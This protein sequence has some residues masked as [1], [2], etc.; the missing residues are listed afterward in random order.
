MEHTGIE[1]NMWNDP[2]L[3]SRGQ[4]TS[5]AS[6]SYRGRMANAKKEEMSAF[7]YEAFLFQADSLSEAIEQGQWLLTWQGE[8][9]SSECALW[10][11]RY[12]V[13]NLLDDKRLYAGPRE[14]CDE[15]LVDLAELDDERFED[16][17]SDEELLFDM[18]EDERKEYLDQKRERREESSYK[19][20]Y[21]D[22][23]AEKE[24]QVPEP[25]FRIHFDVPEGMPVPENEKTLALI[26]RTAKFVNNSSE[27]TMEI[28]L[29]AK[30]ATNPNFAFMSKRHHLFQFYKHVRWLMQTGLYEYAEDIRQR[31]LE[32]A[33]MEQE[34]IDRKA[35]AAAEEERK[36]LQVDL[37]KVVEMTTK[38]LKAHQD[39]PI[40]EKKLLSLADK[41]FDFM[42]PGHIWHDYYMTQKH[43][44]IDI[45]EPPHHTTQVDKNEEIRRDDI[46][47]T[48]AT[49][50]ESTTVTTTPKHT[51]PILEDESP[52][53]SDSSRADKISRV[54]RPQKIKELFRQEQREDSED[55]DMEYQ[56]KHDATLDTIVTGTATVDDADTTCRSESTRLRSK[57]RSQ[58]PP[59]PSSQLPVRKR[60]RL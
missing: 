19:G 33:R 24:E 59:S 46:A 6:L 30:Q 10:L 45:Q 32:E 2:D 42:R 56:Q 7:G 25:T 21:Y 60:T 22:Y 38:F 34:E 39:D 20:I 48:E 16:L 57:S 50:K 12:D 11:D 13:R 37:V 52:K 44:N 15:H 8:D 18:D 3:D 36:R 51:S 53:I 35:A 14:I 29:Q 9:P 27:P 47:P 49:P 43:E 23:N 55:E 5:G 31:E 1:L 40:F 41:R 58:S 26:E 17:D 28:I 4:S 54:D